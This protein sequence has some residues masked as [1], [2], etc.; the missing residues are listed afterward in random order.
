MNRVRGVNHKH[1]LFEI[2]FY[3]CYRSAWSRYYL[4]VKL[5]NAGSFQTVFLI[6]ITIDRSLGH[7]IM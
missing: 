7:D 4:F 5:E 1:C 2:L 3:I 6:I